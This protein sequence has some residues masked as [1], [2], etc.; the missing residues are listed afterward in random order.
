MTRPRRAFG[1]ELGDTEPPVAYVPRRS[2]GFVPA[3]EPHA[4]E[5]VPPPRPESLTDDVTEADEP[6]P[7]PRRALP[8]AA[9]PAEPA[10]AER[11]TEEQ[12]SVGLRGERAALA[13]PPVT[14]P[15]PAP[16]PV[17]RPGPAEPPP[18]RRPARALMPFD[19][20]D[21]EDIPEEPATVPVP[22]RSRAWVELDSAPGAEP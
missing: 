13:A 1:G 6:P 20:S 18:P 8:V 12:A 5:P 11:D 2:S 9:E 10:E 14:P 16:G 15:V 21:D 3:P 22:R 19:P 7:R 17:S 4:V